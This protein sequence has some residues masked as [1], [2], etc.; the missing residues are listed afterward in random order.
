MNKKT[1][2]LIVGLRPSS[3]LQKAKSLGITIL[4]EDVLLD[5]GGTPAAS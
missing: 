3:K 2:Y 4:D 5:A 1:H